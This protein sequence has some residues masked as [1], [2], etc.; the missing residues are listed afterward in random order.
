MRLAKRVDR[1]VHVVRVEEERLTYPILAPFL[2]EVR[3]LIE[4]QGARRLVIDMAAVSYM[5]SAAIG[6]LMDIYHLLQ[7]HDG[8]LKL[9]GLQSRVETMVSMTGLH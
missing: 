6:C 3:E 5:D 7:A 8:A 1:D 9:S 4:N 2:S